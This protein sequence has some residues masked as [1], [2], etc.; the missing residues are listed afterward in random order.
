[1]VDRK[2]GTLKDCKG[3]EREEYKVMRKSER[4]AESKRKSDEG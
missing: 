1:M 2:K 4:G 3:G